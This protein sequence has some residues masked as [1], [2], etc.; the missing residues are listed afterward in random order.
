MFWFQQANARLQY[1]KADTQNVTIATEATQVWDFSLVTDVHNI[2]YTI[3]VLQ[4]YN[5]KTFIHIAYT[6]KWWLGTVAACQYNRNYL[7]LF[8]KGGLKEVF[9][10]NVDLVDAAAQLGAGKFCGHPG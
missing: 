3:Q 1:K 6:C 2:N 9:R 8:N 5:Y 7:I 4:N 10:H